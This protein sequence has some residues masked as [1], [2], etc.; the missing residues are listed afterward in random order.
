MR[1]L[2]FRV[3]SKQYNSYVSTSDIYLR[4]DG[5]EFVGSA[6]S[7]LLGTYS[8]G[9]IENASDDFVVEQYTGFIDKNGKEVYEGDIVE[10]YVTYS[11]GSTEDIVAPV[12]WDEDEGCYAVALERLHSYDSSELEVIGNIHENPELLEKE[13]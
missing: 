2:K 3:W 1:E 13:E 9:N 12:E 10:E 7:M 11:N 4:L 8:L 5:E 6:F